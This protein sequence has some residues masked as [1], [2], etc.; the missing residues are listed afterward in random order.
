MDTVFKHRALKYIC[1]IFLYSICMGWNRAPVRADGSASSIRNKILTHYYSVLDSVANKPFEEQWQILQAFQDAHPGMINTYYK[2]LEICQIYQQTDKFI[3][4]LSSRYNIPSSAQNSLW[5]AGKYYMTLNKWDTS[6]VCFRNAMALQPVP[7]RLIYESAE[8][9]V[10]ASPSLKDSFSAKIRL[11][12]PDRLLWETSIQ[13]YQKEYEGAL[14]KINNLTECQKNSLTVLH[15]WGDC[16]YRLRKFTAADSVW[17]QGLLLARNLG[18]CESEARFLNNL[19]VLNRSRREYK[20]ALTYYDSA[21]V[22]ANRFQDMFTLQKTLGNRSNVYYILGEYQKAGEGYERAISMC[23]QICNDYYRSVWLLNNAQ[24]HFVQGEFIR[25]LENLALCEK[26]YITNNQTQDIIYIKSRI[27]NIYS[28][29]EQK[30]VARQ[31]FQEVYD[32]AVEYN[33]PE[34]QYMAQAELAQYLVDEE[35]FD[36]A[37]QSFQDYI[38]FL[39]LKDDFRVSAFWL[40]C[41]AESYFKENRYFL[42]KQY[43]MKAYQTARKGKSRQYMSWYLLKASDMD[44]KTSCTNRAIKNYQ[45]IIDTAIADD[46]KLLLADVYYSLGDAYLI[47]KEYAKAVKTFIR[48]A[49]I[50][51]ETREKITVEDLKIGYFS[52]QSKLYRKLTECYYKLYIK[53]G[54]PDILEH[55][56]QS[57]ELKMARTLDDIPMTGYKRTTVCQFRCLQRKLRNSFLT[58]ETDLSLDDKL[59]KLETLKYSMMIQRLQAV[60]G[61]NPVSEKSVKPTSLKACRSYMKRAGAC[62]LMYHISE[63]TSF[64]LA[65]TEKK[66]DVIP[67]PVKSERIQ[68]AIDSLIKPFH[69]IHVKNMESVPFYVKVAY[70]LYSQLIQ[71]V[72]MKIELPQNVY[73]VPDLHLLNLPFDMLLTA[74]AN[75]TAYTP[76]DDPDY[77]ESFLLNRYSIHYSPNI[78]FLLQNK[79]SR[80]SRPQMLIMANPF[81]IHNLKKPEIALRS[82]NPYQFTPLPYS[83]MEASG[84]RDMYSRARICTRENANKKVFFKEAPRQ[85]IIHLATHAYIDDNFDAFSGLVLATTEDTTDDGMLMGY[86]IADYRL[87]CDLITLSACETG[88]GEIIAGEGVMGL[89]RIFLRSGAKSVLMTLW[90][91]EDRFSSML[92][93]VFYDLLINKKLSKSLALNKSKQLVMTKNDINSQIH[94]QHPLF[95]ASFMLYGDPGRKTGHI[96]LKIFI[97]CLITLASLIIIWVHNKNEISNLKKHIKM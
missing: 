40:S 26:Y 13:Y 21:A 86:E 71:P 16:L 94:Y 14:K 19:G 77:A 60:R 24:I 42:A 73:I 6:F 49:A 28:Y 56:F 1:W 72:E 20:T 27:A 89:P 22:I 92:M 87:K 57:M 82:M 34:Y 80:P 65:V 74:P 45:V 33:F 15:M 44:C 55:L 23:R 90:K 61:K 84:I 53:T 4:F 25:A 50:I 62:V 46:N 83:E 78:K 67:L 88:R 30:T 85:D 79:N 93:P 96:F 47:K 36:E 18:C 41:I 52:S 76:K 54:D 7:A 11:N 48:A 31:I 97:L 43:Y 95:W 2:L 66:C 63:D 68:S 8:S 38:D 35:E 69:N 51:E 32:L 17:Q 58:T 59:I 3:S 70:W 5:T 81:Q 10:K 39:E 29:L 75:R 9:F 37:R 91:V 64:V 12:A